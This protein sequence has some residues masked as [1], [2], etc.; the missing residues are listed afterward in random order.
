MYSYYIKFVHRRV[1]YF[2]MYSRKDKEDAI[3]YF[4]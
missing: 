3:P 4:L 2:I 1:I